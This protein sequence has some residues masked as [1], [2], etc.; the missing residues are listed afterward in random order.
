M[1]DTKEPSYATARKLRIIE[2]KL[3]ADWRT[4]KPGLSIDAIYNEVV[5]DERKNL[6]CKVQP[7]TKRKID[8]MVIHYEVKMSDLIEQ[9]VSEEYERYIETRH[10]QV[11]EVA[12]DFSG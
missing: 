7:A 2:Q 10:R 4:Q 3:G 8:E 5:G 1:S 11:K 12:K 6:F 9:L